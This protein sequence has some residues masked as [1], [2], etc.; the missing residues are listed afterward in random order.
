MSQTIIKT[1]EGDQTLTHHEY[2]VQ[3]KVKKKQQKNVDQLHSAPYIII[4]YINVRK[5]DK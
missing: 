3:G 5:L 1:H 4:K 2:I